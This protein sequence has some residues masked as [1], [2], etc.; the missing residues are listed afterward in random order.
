MFLTKL[1]KP[2]TFL[3]YLASYVLLFTVLIAAFRDGRSR[4]L[5]SALLVFF[6]CGAILFLLCLAVISWQ[7]NYPGWTREPPAWLQ[8][9]CDCPVGAVWALEALMA[10]GLFFAGRNIFRYRRRHVT[11]DSLKQ[12]MD[13]LPVLFR[14]H[15]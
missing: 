12:A 14:L 3:K 5:R 11:Q 13:L 8:A 4:R 15:Q 7:N 2:S 10:A 1:K 6:L 9:F